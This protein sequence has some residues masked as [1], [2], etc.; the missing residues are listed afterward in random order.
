MILLID[1]NDAERGVTRTILEQA[2]YSVREAVDGASGLA[3][4]R[5]KPPALVLCDLM[6]PGRSGFEVV[7]ELKELAPDARI[8]AISGV[9]FGFADHDTM[10][11]S[12]GL[13]GVVEKPFRPARLLQAVREALG[14]DG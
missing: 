7:R 9:L 5:D 8:I 12:L 6:M 10:K 11:A 13:A 3:L 4:F 2:G 14:K 1:D